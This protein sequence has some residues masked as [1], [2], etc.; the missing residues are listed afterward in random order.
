MLKKDDSVAVFFI[1]GQRVR[2]AGPVNAHYV[3]PS[4]NVNGQNTAPWVNVRMTNNH[5]S[6]GPVTDVTSIDMR[7]YTSETGATATTIDVAAG[8]TL[9]IMTDNIISHAGPLN[10]Y[11]AKASNGNAATFAGDGAVW[12]KVYEIGAV[13]DGGNSITWPAY[14]TPGVSFTIPKNLPS[15]EYLVRV[16]SIAL[17]SAGSFGGAQFYIACGQINI[18]GGGSG[19]PEPLVSIP[20]VYTGYEPGILINIY[21]PVPKNYTVPGPAVWR[22]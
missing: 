18:T 6:H 8:T 12:F 15:G 21:Y 10:V 1:L 19:N 22:G 2:H 4:L 20:G 11:M 3:F 7:C 17:H 5:Y 9:G 14:N 13:T 16:E